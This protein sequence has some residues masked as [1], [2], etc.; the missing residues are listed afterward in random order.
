MIDLT[1]RRGFV[2]N[3]SIGAVGA[4]SL[5]FGIGK[6]AWSANEE[7]VLGIIGTGGRGQSL[8]KRLTRVPNCRMAAVC[9]LRE[10]RRKQAAAIFDGKP[11]QYQDF[12]EMLEKEKL[13]ACIVA[14][15]VGNHAKVVVPVLEAGLNCFSEKPMDANVQNVDAVTRAARK[16]RGIYQIGFQRRYAP[17]FMDAIPHIHAGEIGEVVFMQG[18][19]HWDWGV[20]GWVANVS[21]SGG[22]L[23]EQACHHMDVMNWVMDGNHPVKCTATG[24]IIGPGRVLDINPDANDHTPCDHYSEDQSAVTFLFPNGAIFSY[25]HLFYLA[26]QFTEEKLL[27]HG[28]Q[29]GV[30][31]R[32]GMLYSRDKNV[33]PKQIAEKVPSWEYGTFEELNAFVNE[34]VRNHTTPRSNVETGRVSTLIALMG[35][36]AMYNMQ[37]KEY[38]PSVVTWEDLGTTTGKV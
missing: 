37:K 30:D 32:A 20:G 35:H 26:P 29:G 7:I 38:E 18:C 6:K 23:V 5:A 22:E 36:Q 14:T 33:E 13:D 2:K 25:T 4:A 11:V 24:H 28:T 8:L 21:V 10:D 17:A 1:T 19:W 34:H 16:A 9:D 12:R 3:T 31:L 27:V 15:E